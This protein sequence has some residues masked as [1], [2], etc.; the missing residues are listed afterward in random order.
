[1]PIAID[2]EKEVPS[3]ASHQVAQHARLDAGAHEQFLEDGLAAS[4][5][6]S[7]IAHEVVKAEAR[8][9]SHRVHL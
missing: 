5:R 4:G 7:V 1:M 8:R 9:S 3:F 2:C 6:D